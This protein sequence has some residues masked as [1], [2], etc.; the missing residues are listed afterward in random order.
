MRLLTVLTLGIALGLSFTNSAAARPFRVNQIP[1]GA[2]NGC[3][4]CH[5][6]PAGGGP[7]NPFG[8]TVETSF[9]STPGATGNV[10]WGP[11]L[12]QIDSDGD[13]FRNGFELQ[14]ANG[15]WI[16]GQPAPGNPALV[17]LPGSP[18]SQPLAVPALSTLASVLLA[19]SL[20]IAGLHA[21]RAQRRA[22]RMLPLAG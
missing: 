22:M 3:A 11:A 16:I 1:N 2:I 8:T 10:M 12:A 14:D 6:N 15:A 4:N 13:G 20:L 5:I 7:R 17:T 19:L 18:T 9:L 21:R